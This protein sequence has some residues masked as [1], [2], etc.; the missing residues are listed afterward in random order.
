MDK[1]KDTF[2]D[3]ISIEYLLKGDGNGYIYTSDVMRFFSVDIDK[4]NELK[5]KIEE[6]SRRLN[7]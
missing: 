5:P 4:A 2:Y 3:N 1:I 6:L 7:D